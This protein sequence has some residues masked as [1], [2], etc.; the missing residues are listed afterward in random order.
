MQQHWQQQEQQQEPPQ[1]PGLPEPEQ[2][3]Q[4]QPAQ[5][6]PPQEQLAAVLAAVRGRDAAH[7]RA[8]LAQL[9]GPG[10]QATA[11]RQAARARA[12]DAFEA[13]ADVVFANSNSSESDNSS[14]SDSAE[15]GASASSSS[16]SCSS[17][18]FS[19]SLSDR[20][21]FRASFAAIAA[22]LDGASVSTCGA[23]VECRGLL[24][25]VVSVLGAPSLEQPFD[26]AVAV[27]T[28]MLCC[29]SD[30]H[31]AAFA[32]NACL[33]ALVD[34]LRFRC[35]RGERVDEPRALAT[36]RALERAV[37]LQPSATPKL[38]L[39]AELSGAVARLERITG[40]AG[41]ACAA[42]QAL[43]ARVGLR[44][45]A[46]ARRASVEDEPS[47]HRRKR[48]RLADAAAPPAPNLEAEGCFAWLLGSSEAG[49]GAGAGSVVGGQA[50]LML[51]QND[52]WPR[53]QLFVLQVDL[54]GAPAAVQR[55]AG[56]D[57]LLQCWLPL[58]GF[59]GNDDWSSARARVVPAHQVSSMRPFRARSQVEKAHVEFLHSVEGT[60]ILAEP[61]PVLSWV[62]A[63]DAADSAA[64]LARA[65]PDGAG[66]RLMVGPDC[67]LAAAV[68]AGPGPRELLVSASHSELS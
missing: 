15:D 66:V 18:V 68:G 31:A 34:A 25:E 10:A 5:A 35:C 21:L 40:A 58:A 59:L 9:T 38:L 14:D 62:S 24:P 63:L 46:P 13:L 32:N 7:A 47:E 50:P 2:Q 4:P 60:E 16:R 61:R 52:S 39:Q 12:A 57:G 26:E 20:G 19:C 28:A 67:E 55:W 54:R 8:A 43:A 17:S 37:A 64:V 33:P 49:A 56:R 53:G 42:A 6:A 48:A 3:P 1:Q 22:L 23:A 65:G 29:A 30:E 45:A 41:A 44:P 51:P 36:L 27:V 11:L